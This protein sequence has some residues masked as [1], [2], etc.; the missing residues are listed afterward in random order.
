[1]SLLPPLIRSA[2]PGSSTLT[3]CCDN[4][5]ASSPFFA[6][7]P[8]IQHFLPSR[9]P[10][11]MPRPS[12]R[13]IR[14][15]SIRSPSKLPSSDTLPA[16]LGPGAVHDPIRRVRFLHHSSYL[17][18][19]HSFCT[20]DLTFPP[21]RPTFAFR[22]PAI[23]CLRTNRRLVPPWS[24]PLS[25]RDVLQLV[26]C[27]HLRVR[28][29]VPRDRLPA[30]SLVPLQGSWE[31]CTQCLCFLFPS[32][33]HHESHRPW[34]LRSSVLVPCVLHP[35]P[36]WKT[37]TFSPATVRSRSCA[38]SRTHI[39]AYLLDASRPTLLACAVS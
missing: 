10:A 24:L 32:R 19:L 9:I 15:P 14:S 25:A 20:D 34:R 11:G 30:R 13:T 26:L 28:I 39:H 2:Q 38:P 18:L 17:H 33:L 21:F 6:S 36:V 3:P 31:G 22:P 7:S 4:A 23:Y 27:N 37:L 8:F 16:Y 5:Q 1:M 35:V 29:F 12:R